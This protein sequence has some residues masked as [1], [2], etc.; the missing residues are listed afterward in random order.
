MRN[1]ESDKQINC[2]DLERLRKAAG[3]CL[4]GDWVIGQCWPEEA[5]FWLVCKRRKRSHRLHGFSKEIKRPSMQ[6]PLGK[7]LKSG[8]NVSQSY[9]F[10]LNQ[11]PLFSCFVRSS[12]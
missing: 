3:G 2:S 8:L 12:S 6:R 5:D 9:M 11:C 10:L 4:I 1:Q 7:S